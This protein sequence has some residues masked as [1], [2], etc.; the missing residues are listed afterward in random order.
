MAGLGKRPAT[1]IPTAYRAQLDRLSK[2]DLM[3]IAWDFAMR[4]V[5]EAV[6]EDSQGAATYREVRATHRILAALYGRRPV[7]LPDFA[8]QKEAS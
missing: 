8:D 4:T 2:A 7:A 1:Y 5:G 6:H 3:E